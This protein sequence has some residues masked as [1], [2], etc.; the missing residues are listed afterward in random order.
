MRH[1]GKRRWILGTF[2]AVLLA[3]P[4]LHALPAFHA[5]ERA[6]IAT[7]AGTSSALNDWA[8]QVWK[9]ALSGDRRALEDLLATCPADDE[10]YAECLE[11]VSTHLL[12]REAKRE[13][14]LA[15]VSQ[16]LDTQIANSDTPIGLSMALQSAIELTMLS[17]DKQEALNEPR[18][19]DIIAKA[20]AQAQQARQRGD[21]LT[22]NDLFYRLE[23]LTD[24]MGAY[25]PEMRRETARLG[26]I[27]LYNPERFWELR[28]DRRNAEI[29]WRKANP[30]DDTEDP[31]SE[32]GARRVDELKPLPPYNAMGD[33]F[34]EKLKGIDDTMVLSG[35]HR[36]YTKHVEHAS[37]EDMLRGGLESVKTL[38]ST[39]DLKTVFPGIASA[40]ARRR[41][42]EHLDA[43]A[44]RLDKPGI[45]ELVKLT[46]RLMD[47]NQKTV[48]LPKEAL[49]HEFGNGAMAALDEFSGIIW[50]D[51]IRRFNKSTQGKFVG[52]GV[53]I[54]M[55]PLWNI[56]VVT[57]LDGTPAQ[58]A[59]IRPG[60]VIKRVD[61][62]NT[63]GFTLDQAVD[64]ITGPINTPVTLTVERT[65]TKDGQEEGEKVE[66]DFRLVRAE[67]EETTVKGWRRSG[68]AENAWDW[69]VDPDNKIAYVRLT[70]FAEKT[71][72]EFD[73]AID[74]MRQSG[75][76]GLILD[77]RHNQGGLLEQAVAITSRFVDRDRARSF[78]GRI[79]T[80][81]TKD[82]ALH[83]TERAERGRARLA[84]VPT[85]VLVNE[86]SAS[87]SEIVAGALQDYAK[88]GDAKVVLVGWRSYGK[89]SVQN[90]WGLAS[91]AAIKVTTQYYRLPGGRM[92]HRRPAA[93]QWGVEPDLR[94]EMLPSQ[95]AEAI[96]LRQNADLPRDAGIERAGDKLSD[97]ND[98]IS[99]GTDL[100]LSEALLLLRS[101]A[102]VS[103][104]KDKAVVTGQRETR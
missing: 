60:D 61:G 17:T 37:M 24:E 57:P 35:I 16:R 10:G 88:A 30:R 18:V 62:R 96:S 42:I 51:E 85:V 46:E 40:D 69:F 34:R 54:E 21:W 72:A 1:F 93:S 15:R 12:E 29:A 75:I 97:P 27:R 91:N 95:I 68:A 86:G 103:G 7:T 43:E 49:L 104:A 11:L 98:L 6:R 78:G 58:R 20:E 83:Q 66:L 38:L 89:G 5:D 84:G 102:L 94:V 82:G 23:L 14:R 50:P 44:A 79:V 31:A 13:E 87:A 33:D 77:L 32:A 45:A 3:A 99:K 67:I 71:D 28:N 59:G 47:H 92:I 81:H 39:D 70:K 26:M 2:G 41:M 80:T 52:V 9:A 36:A 74:Q 19:K 8:E 63:E 22:A 90:V 64:V 55:D 76:N 25:K 100:Q 73:R 65:V 4:A 53:Q 101:Q 56:K 48:K